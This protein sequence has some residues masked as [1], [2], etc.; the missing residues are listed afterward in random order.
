MGHYNPNMDFDDNQKKILIQK[1]GEVL[2]D[3]NKTISL[4]AIRNHLKLTAN[5][6]LPFKNTLD[7]Y[8]SFCKKKGSKWCETETWEEL[9]K[10]YPKFPTEQLQ[11]KDS[12][13]KNEKSFKIK[14]PIIFQRVWY[15]PKPYKL[16][17]LWREADEGTLKICAKNEIL[18]ESVKTPKLRI[19]RDH[20]KNVISAKMP[21]DMANSWCVINYNDEKDKT[22]KEAW[23][24]DKPKN[25]FRGVSN[26]QGGSDKLYKALHKFINNF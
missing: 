17:T 26:L 4:T 25:G 7:T 8:C 12:E 15:R 14:E 11:D 24:Q 19:L 3:P 10:K 5:N 2:S 20:I 23:F 1:I 22:E 6:N 18:F 21:G 16:L 9:L 13:K